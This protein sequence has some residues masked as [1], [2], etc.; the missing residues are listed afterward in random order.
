MP[1]WSSRHPRC[2]ASERRH[3]RQWRL[4]A[5]NLPPGT[6]TVRVAKDGLTLRS[7]PRCFRSA[8]Q[9]RSMRCSLSPQVTETVLVEGVI[10]PAVTAIQTSANITASEV[11]VL[12]MGRTPS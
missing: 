10:P 11:N 3:R 4:F 8:P 9:R 2:K 6:Y 12:P 5:A 7:A 1:R